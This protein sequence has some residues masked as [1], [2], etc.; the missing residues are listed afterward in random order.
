[1]Q[2]SSV[3]LRVR[4][5]YK[6]SELQEYQT[7]NYW[8]SYTNTHSHTHTEASDI[9][10]QLVPRQLAANWIIVWKGER[11]SE[12]W[13]KEGKKYRKSWQGRENK[14]LMRPTALRRLLG[15]VKLTRDKCCMFICSQPV[16]QRKFLH[17]IC[18]FS[19]IQTVSRLIFQPGLVKEYLQKKQELHMT[20]RP[21]W[22]LIRKTCQCT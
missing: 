5:Q 19:R 10:R 21:T 3:R 11:R 15:K 9:C 8:G 20:N 1:M 12:G 14:R 2:P 13:G 4:T 17:N 7:G 22:N 16:M 6:V 18:F